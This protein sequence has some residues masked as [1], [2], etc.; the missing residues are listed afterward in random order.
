MASLFRTLFS[1][2]SPKPRHAVPPGSRYYLIGDIHGR[3]DLFDRMIEAID[4]DDRQGGQADSTVVLLGDLIDRGPDSAGVIARARD[5]QQQRAV[6]I[7]AGN[8]EEMFLESFE[9]QAILRHFLRHGGVQTLRSYGI[10]M[11]DIADGP[12]D[13]LQDLLHAAVPKA[14]RA[15]V[16]GFEDCIVAGDYLFVHAGIAPGVPVD[17]QKSSDLRW[18]RERFLSH[19]DPHPQLVIH[20]HTVQEAIDEQPNRIGIDTGA[21]RTGVLTTLVLEGEERRSLQ[22]VDHKGKIAIRRGAIGLRN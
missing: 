3:L 10:A 18:I 2:S 4:D 1:A 9:D 22:A 17:Q 20:G 12:M 5:W 14:D 6:R 21:Y 16:Q 7:L 15:F 19:R 11:D 13:R 8:H